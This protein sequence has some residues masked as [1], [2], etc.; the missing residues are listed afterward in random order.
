MRP[1]SMPFLRL[2]GSGRVPASEGI[3]PNSEE[4]TNRRKLGRQMDADGAPPGP[5]RPKDVGLTA[6]PVTGDVI[7]RRSGIRPRQALPLS[8]AAPAGPDGRGEFPVRFG[9]AG[10]PLRLSS[11]ASPLVVRPVV[12]DANTLRDDLRRAC[13]TMHR[14]SLLDAAARRGLRL[15]CP[16]HVAGELHE[17]LA[18]WVD[19]VVPLVAAHEVLKEH[20]FPILRVVNVPDGPLDPDEGARLAQL[21]VDDRDDV[22]TAILAL[23]LNAPVLTRDR[24]LLRAVHGNDANIDDLTEWLRIAL[25]G[26]ALGEADEQLLFAT[27]GAQLLGRGSIAGATKLIRML[28]S[29]P[30]LAQI[31]ILAGT[32]GL[33][34]AARRPI[35]DFLI[36]VRRVFA[37]SAERLLP[38]LEAWAA[39]RETALAWLHAAA[40]PMGPNSVVSNFPTI[41]DDADALVRLCVYVLGR[42]EGA[43][44][45]ASLRRGLPT[46]IA[47]YVAVTQIRAVLRESVCFYQLPRGRWQ[48][49]RPWPLGGG[50]VSEARC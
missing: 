15:Y 11:G 17:H 29:L 12:V 32:T 4:R 37:Q 35:A 49:G 50:D 34:V 20:Y 44:S 27:I 5:G 28:G 14:T 21:E 25:A 43:I 13:R 36:S 45:A 40:P 8:S 39:E 23:L 1:A 47:A 24:R 30:P 3:N 42:A 10:E 7:Y 6:E 19:G 31:A 2:P 33:A 18:E 22:P 16:E 48:L 26:R 9:M 38:E 46:E 41:S